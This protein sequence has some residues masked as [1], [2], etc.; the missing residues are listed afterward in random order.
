MNENKLNSQNELIKFN[1]PPLLNNNEYMRLVQTRN[2]I[3]QSMLLWSIFYIGSFWVIKIG[4]KYSYS[5]T[6]I[7][8]FFFVG[9]NYYAQK[10]RINKIDK[11]I[12]DIRLFE[13]YN[14]SKITKD[15]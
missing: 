4:M 11:E 10:I 9:V 5:K 14:F 7:G 2:R 13:E 3:T 12:Y 6:I 8:C 1:L 15:S